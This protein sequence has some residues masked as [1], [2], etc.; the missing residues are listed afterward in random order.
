MNDRQRNRHRETT[1][2]ER[3]MTLIELMISLVIGLSLSAAAILIYLN[4]K[5]AWVA[6]DNIARLQESGRFALQLL[7]EDI[8][9]AGYWGLN[10]STVTIANSETID[11]PNECSSGW[12]T[13]YARPVAFA[14]NTNSDYRACIPDSDYKDT[15][16][17]ITI[18]RSSSNPVEIDSITKGNLYLLTSLTEGIAF[19]A[20]TDAELDPGIDLAE[21]PAALYRVLAHAYY[22]RPFSDVSSDAVP[23]LMRETIIG[24]NVSAEPIVEF[25]EDLQITFGLDTIGDGSVD[26]YDNDG[27][28]ADRAG[29]VITV[30]VDLLVR[31]AEPEA[32]YTNTRTYQVGDR[33][34]SF[35]DRFRRQLFRNTVY[36]R[37]R[38]EP[39][40]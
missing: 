4:N 3:G 31:A 8:R 16:D 39:T 14:N 13:D 35:G 22:I 20:D 19:A 38:P 40:L 1:L 30:V 34:H 12:A 23:T 27:I 2:S 7:R 5:Q 29:K 37:N 21:S 26:V 25:I 6:Q 24:G 11:L 33:V 9:L 18:R 28:T 10:L 32:G 15:T 36:L 17:I